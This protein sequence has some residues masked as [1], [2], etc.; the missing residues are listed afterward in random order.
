M[1]EDLLLKTSASSGAY[2]VTSRYPAERSLFPSL[3]GSSMGDSIPSRSVY[4]L[5]TFTETE[6]TNVIVSGDILDEPCS[7]RQAD[8]RLIMGTEGGEKPGFD[9]LRTLQQIKSSQK[10]KKSRSCKW[11]RE[12]RLKP[13]LPNGDENGGHVFTE[14][15]LQLVVF[16]KVF[17]TG[18]ED[19]L[20]NK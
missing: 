1:L 18:R 5:P 7:S 13:L 6:G 17:A 19:P 2:S 4:S 14:E 15:I 20:E 3:A 11:S 12:G 9:S 10:K 16:A 8:V